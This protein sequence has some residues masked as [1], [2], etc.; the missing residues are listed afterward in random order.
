MNRKYNKQNLVPIRREGVC[1]GK[2]GV[3]NEA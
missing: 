2:E 1:R 3:K